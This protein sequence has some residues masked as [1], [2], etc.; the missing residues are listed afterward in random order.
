M[1]NRKTALIITFIMVISS[2]PLGAGRSL[3]RIKKSIEES[4]YTGTE[5]D[6]MSL[7]GDLNSK[8]DYAN[9][10]AT[11]AENSLSGDNTLINLYICIDAL[12]NADSISDKNKANDDLTDCVDALY[13]KL[14]EKDI[15]DRDLKNTESL[16]AG[17]K[18]RNNTIA[19]EAKAYNSNVVDFNAKLSGFPGVLAKTLGLVKPA[20]LFEEGKH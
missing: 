18:S 4:F 16:Y 9:N 17:L 5:T 15:S 20:E 8:I 2:I 6:G 1:N 11:V 10:L 12:K 13:N 19:Y 3:N 14:M 7:N